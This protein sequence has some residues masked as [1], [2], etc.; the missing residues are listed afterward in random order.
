MT[1]NSCVALC[2]WDRIMGNGKSTFPRVPNTDG[3]SGV[4]AQEY[5]LGLD[6]G[7][8]TKVLQRPCL[9]YYGRRNI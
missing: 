6:L 3:K 1:S 4:N 5:W 9:I 7:F 8:P 2:F